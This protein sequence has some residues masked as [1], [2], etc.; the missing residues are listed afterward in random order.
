VSKLTNYR[1]RGYGHI[2][3]NNKKETSKVFN[4]KIEGKC[5]TED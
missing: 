5:P 2:L 1:I 4:R 3:R